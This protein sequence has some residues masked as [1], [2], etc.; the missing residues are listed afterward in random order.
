MTLHIVAHGDFVQL[1][2]NP[3]TYH[4]HLQSHDKSHFSNILAFT[5]VHCD[6]TTQTVSMHFLWSICTI[7]QSWFI[8]G[9]HWGVCENYES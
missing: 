9:M 5:C 6:N 8:Y 4:I 7:S 1:L 2:H 3:A